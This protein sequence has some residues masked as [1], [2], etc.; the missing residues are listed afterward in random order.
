MLLV[1]VSGQ[2]GAGIAA[3][4]KMPPDDALSTDEQKLLRRW[5]EDGA[6][7]LSKTASGKAGHWAFQ[8]LAPPNPPQPTDAGRGRTPVDRFVL[9]KLDQHGLS[10]NPQAD[11]S[12]LIR[13]VSFDQRYLPLGGALSGFLGGLS[14]HQGALRSAFLLRQGLSKEGYIGT[15]ILCAVLVDVARIPTYGASSFAQ[16]QEWWPAVLG[17]TLAAFTGSYLGRRLMH[18]VTLDAVHLLVGWLLVA[19]GAAIAVGIV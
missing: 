1:L 3:E 12:T 8:R 2:S 13:R 11:R 9:S 6:P 14:G 17:G 4:G 19:L 7:G 15:G 5:I 10:L 16:L 18:K